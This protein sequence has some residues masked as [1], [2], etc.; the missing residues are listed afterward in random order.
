MT[1]AEC[2]ERWKNIRA[3]FVRNMKPA[4]SG[5][6]AKTKK[7]YYLMESMQFTVPY[8]KALGAPSGNLPNPPE[9]KEDKESE[10]NDS[11]ANEENVLELQCSFQQPPT[12]S[13]PY[14]SSP[15]PSPTPLHTTEMSQTK[16]NTNHSQPERFPSNLPNRKRGFKNP[17]DKAFLEYFET[18][19]ARALNSPDHIMK[20]DPKTEGL[21]MFLLSMLPDLL[22]MSDEGVRLFKRRALQSVD[23]ILSHSFEYT[24]SN[25]FSAPSTP[26]THS[27]MMYIPQDASVNNTSQLNRLGTSTSQSTA[28][29]YEAV[30]EA[31]SEVNQEKY[32]TQLFD[33]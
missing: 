9:Q 26:S 22:K 5:A 2:K 21:K 15:L 32:N 31:L 6:G 16:K 20:Q 30:N 3:V 4:P 8:I 29:F 28:Q 17:V 19:R 14:P 25:T 10:E 23:D 12:T 24:P 7:T 13:L 27:E 18:K 33:Q 11:T 1:A